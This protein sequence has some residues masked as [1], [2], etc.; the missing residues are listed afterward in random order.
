MRRRTHLAADH[1]VIDA[2]A[3]DDVID[4]YKR[5][6][7]AHRARIAKPDAKASLR[8]I[9]SGDGRL[10]LVYLVGETEYKRQV[11]VQAVTL[12]K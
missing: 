5:A 11:V 12:P 1:L 8:S 4:L 2:Y 3:D 9:A 6:D 10:A 7:L